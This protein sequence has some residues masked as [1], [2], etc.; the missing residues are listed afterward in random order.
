MSNIIVVAKLRVKEEF[1]D[2]VYQEL[3][4]LH[5]ATHENDAGCI[6]YDL[7]QDN[8]DKQS[9]T[10]VETWE[11]QELLAEH[12]KKEHF[13]ACVGKIESMIESISIDKLRKLD[14]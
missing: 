6:Q 8:E 9:F 14:I 7:H 13:L 4:K 1:L 11:S 5:K 10:F 12:E 2:E 3:V